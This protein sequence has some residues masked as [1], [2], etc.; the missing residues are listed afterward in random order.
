[1]ND[2]SRSLS[3]I[4]RTVARRRAARSDRQRLERELAAYRSPTDRRELDAILSRH[5]PEQ[6]HGVET[7]LIHQAERSAARRRAVAR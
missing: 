2:R 5:T 6:T 1:M 4:R 7:I 3:S